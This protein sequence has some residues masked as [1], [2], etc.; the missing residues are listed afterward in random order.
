MKPATSDVVKAGAT[1]VAVSV[2][3]IGSWW[4]WARDLPEEAAGLLGVVVA[5][6]AIGSVLG[7]IDTLAG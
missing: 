1:A 6:A 5:I 7:L 3:G 4:L 2:V